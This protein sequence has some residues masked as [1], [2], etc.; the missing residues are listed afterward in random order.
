MSESDRNY[1][2]TFLYIGN[3]M[4]SDGMHYTIIG[5]KNGEFF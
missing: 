5:Y 1:I 3:P 4:V 2:N